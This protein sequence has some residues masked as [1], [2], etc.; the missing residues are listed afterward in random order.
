MTAPTTDLAPQ[1]VAASAATATA[2]STSAAEAS[3]TE[4]LWLPRA[5]S[6]TGAARPDEPAT[7]RPPTQWPMALMSR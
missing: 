3:A 6:N 1:V 4:P 2:W 7:D 5:G